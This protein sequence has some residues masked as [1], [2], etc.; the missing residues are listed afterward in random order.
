MQILKT[1]AM[2]ADEYGF[3]HKTFSSHIKK[4]VVLKQEIKRGLQTPVKQ[5]LIYVQMGYPPSVNKIDYENV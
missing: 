4:N 2:I 1:L 5:K 3:N